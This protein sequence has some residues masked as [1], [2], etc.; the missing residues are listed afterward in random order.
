[1]NTWY[2]VAGTY[3]GAEM[4]IYV[5]GEPNGTMSKSGTIAEYPTDVHI[6][7]GIYSNAQTEHLDGTIDE[8]RILN[9]ALSVE[10][11]KADY[12][13]GLDHNRPPTFTPLPDQSAIHT[14]TNPSPSPH[15]TRTMTP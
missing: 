8:V 14:A 10:D 12:E 15:P 3:N 2:H 13:T 1:S 11:I 4:R 7:A 5:N 9:I 6:G